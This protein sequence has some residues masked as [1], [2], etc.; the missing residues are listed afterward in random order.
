MKS[1]PLFQPHFTT[2]EGRL[3]LQHTPLLS[4]LRTGCTNRS[5]TRMDTFVWFPKTLLKPGTQIRMGSPEWSRGAQTLMY[6]FCRISHS[7]LRDAFISQWGNLTVGDF[8][9]ALARESQES[10]SGHRPQ[11]SLI[12]STPAH[13]GIFP[14]QPQ[15]AR[16]CAEQDRQ[17]Q[18][19]KPQG[20]SPSCLLLALGEQQQ[21]SNGQL[22]AVL[23]GLSPASAV[24]YSCH[25]VPVRCPRTVL[26]AI[27]GGIYLV[28]LVWVFL[29]FYFSAQARWNS[30]W[31]PSPGTNV[32][33]RHCSTGRRW[34][35]LK[36]VLPVRARAISQM[37]ITGLTA[38]FC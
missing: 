17:V 35:C 21:L 10:L 31:C 36:L 8:G 7:P 37:E 12:L 15:H 23:S 30:G 13:A 29:R 38:I 28:V 32:K 22:W 1:P 20:S 9:G 19:C 11:P 14:S 27:A 24:S 18:P 4:S 25:S 33:T 2:W 3:G 26:L 5:R 34:W 16:P 6:D